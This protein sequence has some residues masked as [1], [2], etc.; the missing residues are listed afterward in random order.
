MRIAA[1]HSR[2]PAQVV[3]AWHLEHGF[4][5]IPKASDREHLSDNFAAQDFTLDAEDM[6]AIDAMD[7]P[8]GRLGPDP[9]AFG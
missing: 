3:I 4:S 2:S 1:K 8:D 6:A 9:M 7:T 5:V